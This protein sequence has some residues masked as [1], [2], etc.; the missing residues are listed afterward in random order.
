MTLRRSL[1]IAV[2]TVTLALVST[3]VLIRAAAAP[4]AAGPLALQTARITIAGTTNIHPYTATTSTVQV[5]RVQLAAGAHGWDDLLAPG[6]V[7][8]FD[9]RI[10]ATTLSSDKDGL[11]KNMYKALKTDKHPDIVFRLSGLDR[12]AAGAVTAKG[13][14]SV[15]GVE[16][17]IA[18]GLTLQRVSGSLSVKGEVPIVMTDYGMTPPKAMLGMLKTDP[19]VIVSFETT[20]AA[21]VE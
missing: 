10:P 1:P 3:A 4:V 12:D 13:V 2:T 21:P 19:T 14:L 5:T 20:I 6:A 7:Q 11:N 8:A 17:P 16:H 9:V 15:A 18:V